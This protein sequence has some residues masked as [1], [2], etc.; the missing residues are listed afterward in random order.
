MPEIQF[1][2]HN[3]R[4]I[5]APFEEHE[6]ELTHRPRGWVSG[7]SKFSKQ[8]LMAVFYSFEKCPF[9]TFWTFTF[10]QD[11]TGD[12]AKK[13]LNRLNMVFNRRGIGWL[14]CMEFTKKGRIHFHFALTGGNKKIGKGKDGRMRYEYSNFI[15]RE[16]IAEL[17]GNGH[18]WACEAYG[19]SGL[20]KYFVKEVA[21]G[22]QK[23]FMGFNGR[24]WGVSRCLNIKRS[25]GV[26]DD[27]FALALADIKGIKRNYWRQD[28]EGIID[29]PYS[30][31]SNSQEVLKRKLQIKRKELKNEKVTKRVGGVHICLSDH[32]G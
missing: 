10:D 29:N 3:N 31:F 8:R 18:V 19:H 22:N 17:W 24:W 1:L 4:V 13:E 25:L 14:W 11:V 30:N 28:L 21:K 23:R 7:F 12:Y 32:G 9:S 27:S 20:R 26:Y 6:L 5:V 16:D 15:P 2:A